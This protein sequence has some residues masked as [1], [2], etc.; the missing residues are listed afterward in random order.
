MYAVGAVCSMCAVCVQCVLCTTL[1]RVPA[2]H[3]LQSH[4]VWPSSS[5]KP[6]SRLRGGLTRRSDAQ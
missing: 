4:H 2:F 5:S 1:T 6:A 3:S